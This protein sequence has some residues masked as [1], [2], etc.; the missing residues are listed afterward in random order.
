MSHRVTRVL[1]ESY[2]DRPPSLSHLPTSLQRR[3]H[4]ARDLDPT[5]HAVNVALDGLDVLERD[6]NV[7]IAA[8]VEVTLEHLT[9][10]VWVETVA[11]HFRGTG[12]VAE[13][14]VLLDLRGALHH[15][16][17]RRDG[18]A[19]QVRQLPQNVDFA[20]EVL[21]AAVGHQ[22]EVL[23]D[24]Y[25]V[26]EH[27]RVE[28]LRADGGGLLRS[29]E[30]PQVLALHRRAVGSRI[31]KLFGVGHRLVL[32]RA[33]RPVAR[34]LRF[35][36]RAEDAVAHVR[37]QRVQPR[38][39]V[40][41]IPHHLLQA[42]QVGELCGDVAVPRAVGGG[43]IH[44]DGDDVADG[45]AQLR[46]AMRRRGLV[47]DVVRIVHAR[48]VVLV[49]EWRVPH[50]GTTRFFAVRARRGQSPHPFRR[51]LT[52]GVHR[53]PR[54]EDKI[55]VEGVAEEAL[56]EEI[57][58]VAEEGVF[59]PELRL[60]HLLPRPRPHVDEGARAPEAVVPSPEIAALVDHRFVTDSDVALCQVA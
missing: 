23:H 1:L 22:A 41:H 42:A 53:H 58:V 45:V 31:G 44:V 5:T 24:R 57:L 33:Q 48:Q 9:D 19:A 36:V 38:G 7:A 11:D 47:D 50:E 32:V 60:R 15:V 52:R 56:T 49:L 2:L 10:A 34:L 40:H 14:V 17:H 18:D 30:I 27:E 35:G 21:A 46:Y 12:P 3:Q 28:L 54:L 6:V 8:S 43:T 29:G 4:L 39:T 26:L 37:Q 59:A 25:L 13:D 20:R 51:R 16:R 55:V